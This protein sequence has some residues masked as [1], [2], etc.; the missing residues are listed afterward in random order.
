MADQKA[1]AKKPAPKAK[2][3]PADIKARKEALKEP[4]AEQVLQKENEKLVAQLEEMKKKAEEQPVVQ[5]AAAPVQPVVNPDAEL[6]STLQIQ[7][8][9]LSDQVALSQAMQIPGK[10]VYKPV[11]A[12]DFQDEGVLFSSRKV[13]YVIG[14]YLD[15]KGVEVM[16]PYKLITLQYA[17]SDRRKEGHEEAIVNSCTFTTHLKAEIEFLRNHP[18]YGVEFFESLNETMSADGVY[19]EFR[20]KAANQVI[21]MKDESVINTCY[22][23]G[24]ANVD[25]MG[26]KD[27]RRALTGVLAE[28][29]IGK[30]KELQSDLE[31]RRMVGQPSS[32]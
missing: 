12:D 17:S 6:L 15:H 16:P 23:K 7:V 8:K 3:S 29:Y 10:P 21:A 19:N 14:S 20:I 32:E 28:E 26:V 25:K 4:S 30:A 31:R 2:L 22:Q 9:L 11:P 18:M 24:V 13:F 27:L 1:Q 5:V